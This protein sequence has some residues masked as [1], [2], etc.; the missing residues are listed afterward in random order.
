M[1]DF[2][3]SVKNHIESDE[4]FNKKFIE[5]GSVYWF[6]NSDIAKFVKFRKRNV[7]E[8]FQIVP[9]T[10]EFLT[11]NPNQRHPWIFLK[12]YQIS[13]KKTKKAFLGSRSHFEEN[14]K[15]WAYKQDPHSEINPIHKL[16]FINCELNKE[17]VYMK[18]TPIEQ[19]ISQDEMIYLI[20]QSGKFNCIDEDINIIHQKLNEVDETYT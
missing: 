4:E 20:N 11:K 17:G 14:K 2:K 13:S 1:V 12:R 5:R 9:T 19:N 16:K 7:G 6:K 15:G 18:N 10:P 8:N 3:T